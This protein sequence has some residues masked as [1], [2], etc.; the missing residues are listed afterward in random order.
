MYPGLYTPTNPHSHPPLMSAS[1]WRGEGRDEVAGRGF[2]AWVSTRP[3]QPYT[4]NRAHCT[5]PTNPHSHPPLMSAS[6]WRGE[7][8]INRCGERFSGMGFNPSGTAEYSKTHTPT[9]PHSPPPLMSASE[10]RALAHVKLIILSKIDGHSN[11]S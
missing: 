6:E 2:L 3:A 4:A 11:E 8:R 7:G 5:H 9:N 1:E 10:W